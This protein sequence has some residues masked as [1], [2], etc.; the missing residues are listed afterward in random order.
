M[1]ESN[2]QR[3]SAQFEVVFLWDARSVRLLQWLLKPDAPTSSLKT[4]IYRA[5]GPILS[6]E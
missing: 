4:G 6:M 2:P 3:T 1:T 5:V